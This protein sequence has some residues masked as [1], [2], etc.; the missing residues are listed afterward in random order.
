MFKELFSKL[1]IIDKYILKRYLATFSIMLLL[2]IPIG[3]TIDVAEK[4]NKILE[5]KVPFVKVA[6]YYLDFI[7]YFAN[8][9]FP[10]FLFL[11][12]IWF[13]SKLASNTEIV[14]ILSS[15][16]SFQRFLKPYIIG[17][18]IVSIFALL[19]GF[20][21]MPS[22]SDGFRNFRYNYLIGGGKEEMRKTNDVYRQISDSE[23]IYASNL[24]V[25]S[26]TAYNFVL[27]KFDKNKM[28]YKITASSIM[29][30]PKEKSYV[31]MNYT[32]RTVGEL[33]DVIES[34]MSKNIKFNFELEDLTPVVYIAETLMPNELDRFIEKERKR[35]S[36]NI[37]T[38][39]VVKYR[40]YSIP[41]SAFILT[42]IAVA[43][44]SM[45]RRGGMG[46]N[47]AIGIAI[48]FSYVFLD[49]I[50]GTMAEKSSF[51]PLI[52]VWIPNTIFG[53]LA[54]YLLKNAKR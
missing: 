16:I 39:L 8:N 2:F 51:S 12:I 14:A 42:I 4:V 53:I 10:I 5:N 46:I 9:L 49:K 40:K 25:E 48:A 54:Y 41:I 30:N 34:N 31:L 38:Y 45:K 50:F 29:Y 32:K 35:G 19:V 21:L 47:L 17:A 6:S 26:K 23:F 22:A 1:T 44:S 28:L 11:S 13:T 43:V 7:I 33:N 18:T 27:E 24:N 36:S 3:I 52:A 20:F 37:N 15:G